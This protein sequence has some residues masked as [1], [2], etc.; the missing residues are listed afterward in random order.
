[1][2]CLSTVDR[3][4]GHPVHIGASTH[5]EEPARPL[6]TRPPARPPARRRGRPARPPAGWMRP[7]AGWRG[8]PRQKMASGL[9][10]IPVT[11]GARRGAT[12]NWNS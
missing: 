11:P 6:D 9:T 7:P 5:R 8:R 3:R 12:T 4:T 2:G 10:A 1:M